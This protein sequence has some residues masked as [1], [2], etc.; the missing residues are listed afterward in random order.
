[1]ARFAFLIFLLSLSFLPS[2]GLASDQLIPPLTDDDIAQVAEDVVGGSYNEFF[3]LNSDEKLAVIELLRETLD[4]EVF[5]ELRDRYFAVMYAERN[6]QPTGQGNCAWW[7]SLGQS[8]RNNQLVVE[9]LYSVDQNIWG[10]N[11]RLWRRCSWDAYR[12]SGCCLDGN[13]NYTGAGTGVGGQ[14]KIFARTILERA[15]GG[16]A[17]LPCCD[18]YDYR[19]WYPYRNRPDGIKYAQPGE[20]IQLTSP[21]HTAIIVSNLGGGWFEVVDSNWWGCGFGY[22]RIAKHIF[23]VNDQNWSQADLKFYVIDCF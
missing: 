2:Q 16:A 17:T 7:S 18:A 22:E 6:N 3:D 10:Q 5:E 9:A 23:N 14:C 15:S 20:L 13:W 8:G 19:Q 1:M 11:D 21:Y 12:W 4:P